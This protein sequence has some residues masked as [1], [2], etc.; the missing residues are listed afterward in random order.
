MKIYKK[1]I[2]KN[3]QVSIYDK[4]IKLDNNFKIAEQFDESTLFVEMYP[5]NDDYQEQI[6]SIQELKNFYYFK[7]WDQ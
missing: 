6:S 3:I 7:F 2:N 4:F 5:L 1:L